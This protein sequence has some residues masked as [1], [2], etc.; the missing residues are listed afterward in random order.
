M[1]KAMSTAE[2]LLF[3]EEDATVIGTDE[4]N[5]KPRDQERQVSTPLSGVSFQKRAECGEQFGQGLP[6]WFG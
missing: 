5:A 2:L 1:P 4:A 3:R 6:I